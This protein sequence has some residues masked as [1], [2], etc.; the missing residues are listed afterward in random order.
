MSAMW[1]DDFRP[2]QVWETA[3]ATITEPQILDFAMQWDPQP[4]HLDVEAAAG[5][6]FRGL[7]ASGWQTA[8]I[9]FRLMLALGIFDRCSMGSPGLESLKWLKPVRPGD[10]LRGRLEVVETR[11]SRSKPDRGSMVA[12]YAVSN[13]RGETVMTWRCVH[14]LARRPEAAGA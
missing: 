4:F 10:T 6:S 1:F 13:Q 3:G 2:G 7:I 11:P 9:G 8:L 14:I 12:D 5:T